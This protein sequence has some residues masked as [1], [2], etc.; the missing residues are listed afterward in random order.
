MKWKEDALNS[1]KEK[2]IIL[3]NLSEAVITFDDTELVFANQNAA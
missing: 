3:D 1:D 2:K